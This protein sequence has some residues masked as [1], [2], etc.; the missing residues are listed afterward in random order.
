MVARLP[1][2]AVVVKEEVPHL[3][4]SYAMPSLPKSER[5]QSPD[6]AYLYRFNFFWKFFSKSA[7]AFF[8]RYSKFV[9][10]GGFLSGGFAIED[11]PLDPKVPLMARWLY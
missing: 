9:L 8:Y 4:S 1:P 10:V 5:P 2:P 11:A 6:V 7:A 3:K